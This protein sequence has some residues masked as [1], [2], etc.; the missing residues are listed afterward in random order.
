MV[1]V[2]MRGPC[3][4]FAGRGSVTL[5]LRTTATAASLHSASAPPVRL[6]QRQIGRGG[7][8][9]HHSGGHRGGTVHPLASSSEAGFIG[10]PTN[11]PSLLRDATPSSHP[12][13]VSVLRRARHAGRATRRWSSTGGFGGLSWTSRI[14]GRIGR[15]SVKVNKRTE[16]QSINLWRAG[17]S[18]ARIRDAVVNRARNSALGD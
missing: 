13:P 9:S 6:W 7:D 5:G 1:A 11:G 3:I 16:L 14:H 15:G 12:G 10:G 17:T 4:S 18:G 8:S 2:G